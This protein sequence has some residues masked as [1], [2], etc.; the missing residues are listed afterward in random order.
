M[1]KLLLTILLAIYMPVCAQDTWTQKANYPEN[2][3]NVGAFAIGDYGYVGMGSNPA[4]SFAFRK[5][6]PATNEWTSIAAF[7][8]NFMSHSVGFTIDDKGYIGTGLGGWGANLFNTQFWQYDPATNYWKQ[9]A[10]FAGA[11]RSEAAGFSVG[12]KGYIGLGWNQANSYMSD[13]WQFTPETNTWVQLANFP[14]GARNGALAFSINGKGYIGLGY[15]DDGQKGDMWEYDPATNVWTQ[16]ND[17]PSA[18]SRATSFVINNVCY[19]GTGNSGLARLKDFYKYDAVADSW[20]PIADAGLIARQSGIGMPINGK[21][22]IGTGADIG[23]PYYNDFWEYTPQ[24]T[25]ATLLNSENITAI[26][27]NPF[28]EQLTLEANT[29]LTN[30]T[31]TL[32]NVTGQKVKEVKNVY[33]KKITVPR[34]NLPAGLYLL[35]VNQSGTTVVSQKVMVTD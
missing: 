15:D 11:P 2:I 19:A 16:K 23:A 9:M 21:G 31:L 30:G 6:D 32:Y 28:K 3:C 7:P 25:A 18:R 1:K 10:D 5:Y 20:L 35:T 34:G 4:Q 22:Y 8:G 12:G 27:P 33:G 29:D 13:M 17:F 14:G 24:N 26:Y